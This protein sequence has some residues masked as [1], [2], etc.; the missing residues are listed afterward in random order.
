MF[1]EVTSSICF[2]ILEQ[3]IFSSALSNLLPESD[4]HKYSGPS[5]VNSLSKKG[6]LEF[7]RSY[8]LIFL[9]IIHISSDH[10]TLINSKI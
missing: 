5:N 1:P 6:T 8:M 2:T 10:W 4:W 3:I 9:W 7:F